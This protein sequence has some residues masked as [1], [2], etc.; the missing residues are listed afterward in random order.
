MLMGVKSA[1]NARSAWGT[2]RCGA[3]RI[4][5]VHTLLAKSI[6]VRR[7]QVLTAAKSN[8]IPALVVSQYKQHVG[9]LVLSGYRLTD[10]RNETEKEKQQVFDHFDFRRIVGGTTITEAK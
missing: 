7:L 4:L 6:D 1:E 8:G 3:E 2:Q 10:K 5:E 9:P